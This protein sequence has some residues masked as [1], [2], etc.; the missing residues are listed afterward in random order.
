MQERRSGKVNEL[1][2]QLLEKKKEIKSIGEQVDRDLNKSLL[3]TNSKQA[4]VNIRDI[5]SA[6]PKSNNPQLN[7]LN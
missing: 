5:F 2:A 4:V 1:R 3:K 6:P 7:A